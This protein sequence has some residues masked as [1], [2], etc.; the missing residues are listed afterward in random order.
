MSNLGY[1]LII[2]TKIEK[3][4]GIASATRFPNKDPEETESPTI[5]TIP[6]MAKRIEKKAIKDTFSF[7]TKY[8]KIAKNIV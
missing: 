8:P 7:K 3:F 5:I 6:L 1:F 2:I 4:I